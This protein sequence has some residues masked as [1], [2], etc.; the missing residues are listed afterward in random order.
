MQGIK[1]RVSGTLAALGVA[2]VA[3]V[4]VAPAA[5]AAPTGCGTG[6]ANGSTFTTGYCSGGT[7]S[8]AVWVQCA[9]S[10]WP[11]GWSFRQSGWTRPGSTAWVFCPFPSTVVRT[12][13]DRTGR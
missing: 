13:I 4:A 5:S 7:G 10:V 3:T 12:G 6:W 9:S 2:A 8:F 11:Y 1:R